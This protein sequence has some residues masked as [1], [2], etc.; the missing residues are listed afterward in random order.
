MEVTKAVEAVCVGRMYEENQD[1]A[2]KQCQVMLEEPDLD[3]AVRVGDI[4]GF[5]IEHYV[6]K[7]RWK[8]VSPLAVL[9]THTLSSTRFALELKG[10]DGFLLLSV[11][12]CN[13]ILSPP[14]D[15]CALDTMSKYII[16]IIMCPTLLSAVFLLLS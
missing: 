5:L 9:I 12:Q 14:K 7:E 15:T 4:Y 6:R 10:L 1:E 16:I 3:S 11:V 2:A 8:A 13:L